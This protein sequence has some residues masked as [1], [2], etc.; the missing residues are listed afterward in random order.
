MNERRIFRR[1]ILRSCIVVASALLVVAIVLTI[2]GVMD[3]KPDEDL[4]G[5]NDETRQT[6]RYN[7]QWYVYNDDI[8]TILVMGLDKYESQVQE[9]S[10]NNDMQ[11]DFLTL[12]ILDKG[13]DTAT[14]LHLNRDAMAQMN[15]LGLKGEVVDTTTAQLALAHTYGSGGKDSGKNTAD[16]VSG[17][18]YDVPVDHY[19]SL[20]MDAVQALNDLV[21][22]VTVTVL[23]DFSGV[24]PTLVKGQE[25]TLKGEQALTY[26]RTRK[27]VG[28][29]TN[30]LRMKRQQQYMNKLFTLVTNKVTTDDNFITRAALEISDYMVS[31]CTVDQLKRI[32]AFVSEYSLSDIRS[33]EGESIKGEKFM[34]FYPDEEKLQEMIIELFF[35]P[36]K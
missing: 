12:L 9:D 2:I 6:I 11:A 3:K 36:K 13:E 14:A 4:L 25:I 30:A 5:L 29:E 10:Y 34:E 21:D 1:K 19:L 26:V 28:D 31:D 7:G 20:T 15:V 33:I 32:S 23:D 27:G 16:A 8:E 22:G 18:L 24:D 35:E 17:F